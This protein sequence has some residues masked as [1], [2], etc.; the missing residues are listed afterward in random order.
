MVFGGDGDVTR[1]TML[2]L[3]ETIITI[4]IYDLAN[5]DQENHLQGSHT[6]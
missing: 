5:L 2:T 4:T 1:A 6:T 3:Q